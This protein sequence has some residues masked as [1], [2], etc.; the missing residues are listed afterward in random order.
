[1]VYAQEKDLEQA[2]KQFNLCIE[3]LKRL[4]LDQEDKTCAC[5]IV[6]RYVN[7]GIE[8]EEV[9]GPDLLETATS[10]LDVVTTQLSSIS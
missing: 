1:M 7:G 9:F 8:F 5:L 10:A 2:K 6:P 3:E 4:D